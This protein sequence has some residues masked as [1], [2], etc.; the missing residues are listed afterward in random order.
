MEVNVGREETVILETAVGDGV[1]GRLDHLD[2]NLAWRS[3]HMNLV[4]GNT[5]SLSEIALERRQAVLCLVL[6]V[7]FVGYMTCGKPKSCKSIS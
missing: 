7:D 1:R 2:G 4:E 3:S 5:T 6:V